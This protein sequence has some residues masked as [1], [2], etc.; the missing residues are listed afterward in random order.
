MHDDRRRGEVAEGEGEGDLPE[1]R[2]TQ[3]LACSDIAAGDSRGS[4]WHGAGYELRLRFT[5]DDG[6]DVGRLVAQGEGE[7]QAEHELADADGDEGVAPAEG[8]DDPGEEDSADAADA[9]AQRH[10]AQGATSLAAGPLRDRHVG[11]RPARALM[12]TAMTIVVA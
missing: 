8:A 1:G 4:N 6:A 9:A 7:G 12:P 2:R 5:I 3:R 10:Q 11:R